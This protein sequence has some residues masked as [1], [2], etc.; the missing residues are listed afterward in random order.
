ML[1]VADPETSSKLY[2]YWQLRDDRVS[3]EER[4]MLYRRVLGRGDTQVLSRMVVNESFQPLWHSLM[5]R[6]AEYTELTTDAAR[7]LAVSKIPIQ[8][9]TKDLQFNLTEHM[10]GMAHLQVTDMYMQLRDAFELLGADEV[11]SQISMGRRRSVWTTIERLHREELNGAP[12]IAGLRTLAVEG[13]KVFQWIADFDPARTDADFEVF[14]DAAEA[15]II[16]AASVGEA[17]P[18]GPTDDVPAE[19]DPWGDDPDLRLDDTEE[20]AW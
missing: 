20:D 14:R 12:D 4:G 6:V 3:A 5:E 10:T 16:A 19:E 2:R 18:A 11:T 1:D 9:A 15:W 17:S 13:N 7:E 8:R